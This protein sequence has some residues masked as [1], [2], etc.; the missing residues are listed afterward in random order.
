[1]V[2]H[3]SVIEARYDIAHLIDLLRENKTVDI[4]GVALARLLVQDRHGLL[5]HPQG[6]K[7]LRDVVVEIVGA[8]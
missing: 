7:T 3:R 4:R 1:M 2:D 5:I 8:L 6:G